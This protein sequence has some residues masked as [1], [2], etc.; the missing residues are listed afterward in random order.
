M[1]IIC[2]HYLKKL[3]TYILCSNKKRVLIN[4]IIYINFFLSIFYKCT[5]QTIVIFYPFIPYSTRKMAKKNIFLQKFL[6]I[7]AVYIFVNVIIPN[8]LSTCLIIPPSPPSPPSLLPPS[9]LLTPSLP[10]SLP[11]PL[12][13]LLIQVQELTLTD[14]TRKHVSSFSTHSPQDW[15]SL[16]PHTDAQ[17]HIGLYTIREMIYSLSLLLQVQTHIPTYAHTHIH[18]S[19]IH[20]YT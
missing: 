4:E 20:T 7:Y 19:H 1:I 12:S 9:S 14:Y 3:Q 8:F 13:P 17:L 5:V 16:T 15:T 18:M 6:A 2:S 10:L 11:P